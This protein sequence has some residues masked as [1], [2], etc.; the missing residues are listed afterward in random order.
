MIH[1][2]VLID[3]TPGRLADLAVELAETDG[4]SEVYS[5]AGK[6]DIVA[7]VRVRHHE[8]LADVVTRQIASLD[9]IVSTSTLVAFQA[10]SKSDLDA[11]WDV[12]SEGNAN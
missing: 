10:Y 7:I 4:V 8:D 11:V 1:A 3:A 5:V 2:F 6:A 12:G 9:G